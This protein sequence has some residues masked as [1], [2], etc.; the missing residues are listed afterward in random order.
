MKSN[1]TQSRPI[2]WEKSMETVRMLYMLTGTFPK[3]EMEGLGRMIRN[4]VIQ[5]PILVSSATRNGIHAASGEQI[6]QA[7]ALIFEIETLLEICCAVGI[8]QQQEC[9]QYQDDLHMLGRELHELNNRVQR[10]INN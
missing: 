7:S 4:K 3:E 5:L 10:R 6:N 2:I 8:M 9:I 1:N